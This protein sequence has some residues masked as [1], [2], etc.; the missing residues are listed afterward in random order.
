MP[1]KID[2][3]CKPLKGR[4]GI[5]YDQETDTNL[6]S[7]EDVM[8]AINFYIKYKDDDEK[9][10]KEHPEVYK[11]FEKFVDKCNSDIFSKKGVHFSAGDLSLDA[12]DWFLKWCF[13]DVVGDV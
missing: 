6:F 1:Y 7:E 13:S 2:R 12:Y 10:Q 3:F 11:E 4:I 9:L 5:W 8:S